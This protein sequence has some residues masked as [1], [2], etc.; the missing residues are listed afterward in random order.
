MELR[1]QIF[2]NTKGKEKQTF[3]DIIDAFDRLYKILCMQILGNTG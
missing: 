1:S 2:A 3:K